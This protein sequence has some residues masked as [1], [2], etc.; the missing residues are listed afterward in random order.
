MATA[1]ATEARTFSS[2]VSDLAETLVG[3]TLLEA[4]EL[5]DCLE[6]KYGIKPAGGGVMMAAMPASSDG[7]GAAAAAE[8]TE[9]DVVLTGFGDAKIN[10]IKAIRSITSLGLKEAKELVEGAPK[11]VK[12]AVSK[13][14]AEKIK[15]EITDAGGTAEIK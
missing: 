10:V 7:G 6:E 11:P 14:D 12:Q 2:K 5:A 9:F 13:E 3:L 8:Q 15:K 1:E 4:Q